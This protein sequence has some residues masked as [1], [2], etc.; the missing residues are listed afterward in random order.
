MAINNHK[1]DIRGNRSL[2]VAV[3]LNVLI[4]VAEVI[5]GL[6]SNS[7]AL[8][9]DALHNLGD[10]LA[11]LFAYLARRMS[12]KASNDH[13]TF[14]YKRAEILAAFINGLLLLG[15]SAYLLVEA[16]WRFSNPEPV[17][18][19]M[20]FI[21]AS[22]G[23]V[24]NLVAMLLL[25]KHAA[26][27]LN[28]KTAYLHLLG[29]TF[30]SLAVILGGLLIYWYRIYWIDPLITILV[31]LYIMHAALKVLRPVW[32]ILMQATPAGIDMGLLR[33][34]MEKIEGICDIHHVHVWALNEK[35]IHFECHAGLDSNHMV[36]HTNSIRMQMQKLLREKFGIGHITIQFEYEGCG[37]EHTG[38]EE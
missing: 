4:T 8:L 5:G 24:L 16:F 15:V 23:L 25:R 14:G 38:I 19:L 32:N 12:R 6:L 21:V 13:K 37:E 29:D 10:T 1:H 7:L 34:E 26:A 2:L 9:S 20:V 36:A 17:K 31:S 27:N 11:I 33:E 28:I 22:A 35:E 18:G 30:S 3:M